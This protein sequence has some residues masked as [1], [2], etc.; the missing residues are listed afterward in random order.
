MEAKA[1]SK[2]RVAFLFTGQGSQRVGMGKQLYS[3]ED[4][5][6]QFVPWDVQMIS[7]ET[8]TPNAACH[9]E[10]FRSALDV[11]AEL[12]DP[13]LEMPLLDVLFKAPGFWYLST[14]VVNGARAVASVEAENRDLL[15]LT[16]CAHSH[17][18]S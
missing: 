16:K 6:N 13:L 18:R 11:C 8:Q 4:S 3:S 2:K 9:Q 12:L 15:N 1:A 14:S 5:Q 10:S 7:S 17:S